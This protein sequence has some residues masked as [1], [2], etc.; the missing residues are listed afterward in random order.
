MGKFLKV[1]FCFIV[2][3]FFLFS[4]K[5][6]FTHGFN[7]K[8]LMAVVGIALFLSDLYRQKTFA[9]TNEFMGLLLYSGLISLM[10]VFSSTFHNTQEQAYTTYFMSMLV[11]LSSSYVVIRCIKAVHGKISI[12]LLA[13]YIVVVSVTQG[14][15]AVIADNYAPL[16]TFILRMVPGLR[17]SKLVNRLYGLGDTAT[18]DTGGIRFAI[19]SL[20][21][22]HNIKSLVSKDNTKLIPLYVLAFLLLLFT[23]NMIARTSLVGSAI[24]LGYLL[25][26]ISPFK[27]SI[28]SS[29]FKAWI[30]LIIETLA[31]V[32][33]VISL[34]NTDEK[35]YNRTRFAFEGFFSLAEEGHWQTG[36][37]DKL[38]NMIVFPDNTE[39]WLIG[40]GY[41][42]SPDSDPYYL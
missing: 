2:V 31:V 27:S 4:T 5:F 25:V 11:W 1:L 40:D 23:G 17:W 16:D 18:L 32:I 22:A 24:G 10:A 6:Y 28:T 3:D 29:T 33:L 37:N 34:Y 35:F 20:L 41:F 26:Y 36:S 30:W 8:E 38:S 14:L 15:I 7:T 12:E 39:T 13:S 21:C 19:A 9:I 42:V